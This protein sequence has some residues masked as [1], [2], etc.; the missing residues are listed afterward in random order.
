MVRGNRR[1]AL[2]RAGIAGLVLLLLAAIPVIVYLYRSLEECSAAARNLAD[3]LTLYQ[4]EVYVAAKQLPKGTVLTEEN[5]CLEVRYSDEAIEHYMT[6]QQLGMVT[7]LDV[8][9]GTCLTNGM[10][11][12]ASKNIRTV[13]FSE[14]EVPEHIGTGDRIDVRIR[15]FNAE[16]YTVLSDKIVVTGASGNGMLLDLTEEELL[17]LSS[18]ISDCQEYKGTKLYAVEYPEYQQSGSGRVNYIANEEILALLEREK[19]EGESRAA[20]EQRLQQEK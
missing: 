15:Y 5:V 6:A 10:L 7:A 4:K 19:K 1:K 20:L 11:A 17:L 8:E 9:A 12:E 14:G 2:K 3:R 18:A 16:D 13:F